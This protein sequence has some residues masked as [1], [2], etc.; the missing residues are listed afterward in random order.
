MCGN[1]TLM[2]RRQRYMASCR[3]R[4]TF[5]LRRFERRSIGRTENRLHTAVTISSNDTLGVWGFSTACRTSRANSTLVVERVEGVEE[6]LLGTLATGQQL[7]VVD[8]E[9]VDLPEALLELPHAV[10]SQRRD[11]VVHE[12]LGGQV[13]DARERV[14]L[15]DLVPDRVGEVCLAEADATVDEER[16]VVVARLGRHGLARRVRELVRGAD[17]EAREGVLRIEGTQKGAG[18]SLGVPAGG[19]REELS[20]G[21]HGKLGHDLPRPEDRGDTRL[22]ERK[23]P[24]LHALEDQAI[25]RLEVDL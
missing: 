24:V 10:A 7:H 16:I 6:L 5:L 25:R 3:G 11:E 20:L 4:T 12:R 14:A 13:G 8:D 18:A 17:D 23:V 19:V 1:D 2:R 9:H 22:D 15:E 21:A